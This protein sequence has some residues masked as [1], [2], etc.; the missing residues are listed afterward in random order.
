MKNPPQKIST[1]ST[2][3]KSKSFRFQEFCLVYSL[4]EGT[5]QVLVQCGVPCS[6]RL[7]L[8]IVNLK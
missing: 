7:F 6:R 5:G 4:G 8:L 2:L 3:N 1:G